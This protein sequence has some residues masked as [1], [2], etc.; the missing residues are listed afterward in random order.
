MNLS[1]ET[2]AIFK[3]FSNINS[4]LSIKAGNKLTT[5]SVH[6]NI[7]AEC[8]VPETFPTDFGIYDLVEFLGAMSLFENPDLTFSDKYVSIQEGRNSVKYFAAESSVL[9]VV[10]TLKDFPEPDI[11]FDMSS[12]ML[13][14]IQR[15]AS[16][17]RVADFS[18]V[19]DG[20]T[21]VVN[22]GDKT[23]PTGNSYSSEIGT[24]DK[25]FKINFKTEN[26]KMMSGD[27]RVSIGNKKLSRFQATNQQLTYF[28]ALE[29]DSTFD[30]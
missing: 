7:I 15:V 2:L 1:K 21:I 24:T 23:N 16:I 11:E 22:V 27:Y 8:I 18:I 6:R 3:N 20:S 25:T 12:Q 13:N 30:F 5:I 10:P 26:L 29:L 9:T 4:N 17:L 19:G 28:V 14:Q